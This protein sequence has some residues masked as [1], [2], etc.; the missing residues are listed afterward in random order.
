M[1]GY[2]VIIEPTDTGYSAYSPDLYGCVTTGSTRPEAET[3]IREAVEFHL[4]GLAEEGQP[5]PEPRTG[6]THVYIEP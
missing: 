2:L 1:K 6:Y 3:N 4:L 5:A